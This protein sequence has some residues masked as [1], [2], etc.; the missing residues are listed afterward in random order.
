M[1]L[2]KR[3]YEDIRDEIQ[4]GDV[5]AFSGSRPI[6]TVIKLVTS[7][8]VSHVGII[9]PPDSRRDDDSDE[10]PVIAEATEDGIRTGALRESYTDDAVEKL[11][12]LRLDSDLSPEGFRRYLSTYREKP[13]DYLQAAMLGLML[14][15][16]TLDAIDPDLDDRIR[17]LIENNLNRG[18][19]SDT[20][21]RWMNTRRALIGT[22]T[23]RFNDMT[24]NQIPS[25]L[26]QTM[27]GD[28]TSANLL[29][30]DDSEEG[31]ENFFCSEF[32]TRALR[33]GGVID[34]DINP[35]QVTPIELCRFHLYEDN[36]TQFKGEATKIRGFNC[37]D[38]S[39]WEE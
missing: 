10:V 17:R 29:D 19:G 32:V 26:I 2:I 35:E 4:P 21:D 36:Y 11:W 9:V 25:S 22:L 6:S 8:H 23:E 1:G 28:N 30:Q 16:P 37:V 27:L 13:Y 38:P 3:E 33:A 14:L 18:S 12:W 39:R 24:G 31:F 5:I 7:S 34:D 15:Q 20:Q